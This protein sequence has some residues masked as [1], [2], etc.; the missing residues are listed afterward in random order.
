VLAGTDFGGA[1]RR[2]AAS[3]ADL[4][5]EVVDGFSRTLARAGRQL[6]VLIR[7]ENDGTGGSTAL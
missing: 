3:L 1:Q 7:L 5:V 4:A 2:L 6:D